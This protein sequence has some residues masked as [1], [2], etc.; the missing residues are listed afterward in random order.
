MNH[1]SVTMEAEISVRK[2]YGSFE[3]YLSEAKLS[4]QLKIDIRASGS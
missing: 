1:E 4:N 3:G 2:D